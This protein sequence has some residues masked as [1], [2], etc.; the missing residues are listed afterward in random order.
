M[1]IYLL[2]AIVLLTVFDSYS[3]KEIQIFELSP[4]STITPN[5]GSNQN[6]TIE[7][8]MVLKNIENGGLYGIRAHNSIIDYVSLKINDLAINEIES[9]LYEVNNCSIGDT[10]KVKIQSDTP[11]IFPVTLN[12]VENLKVDILRTNAFY[13]VF[14]GLFLAIILYNLFL[15]ISIRD[16]I[17]FWYVLATLFI[18]LVQLQI[19][20]ILN[21]WMILKFDGNTQLLGALSGIFTIEFSAL[22]LSLRKNSKIIFLISRFALIIYAI[23]ILLIFI[24]FQSLSYQLIN[25]NASISLLLLLASIQAIIRE[26]GQHVFFL[27]AWSSFLLGVTF[28]ALKDFGLLPFNTFTNFALPVG[29]VIEILLLSF[30]LADRINV[31]KQEKEISQ[32]L[33]F[34]TMQ[35]NERLVKE[36]NTYLEN[37]VHERTLDLENRNSELNQ[38]L[39]DL[40]TTQQQLVESEKLA[41]LG[42]MTAGIAHEINNPINF[43]Q[44]NVG[45]LKRDVQDILSLLEQYANLENDSDLQ[46]KLNNLKAQYKNLEIDFLKEEISQLLNGIEE[47]SKRTAEI[48]KGLRI[49]SRMDKSERVSADINECLSS[50]LVV[51]KNMTKAEVTL[52]IHLAKD[53]PKI[54]CYPGKLSQV[55]MN[56]ITNA[57]QATKLPNR[58]PKDRIIT[59]ESV[60]RNEY[61]LIHISDNGAGIPDKIHDKIFEPFFTTKDVGEGT[62]L[63]LSIVHGIV[64]EHNGIIDFQNVPEGGT[65]FTIHLPITNQL[66][67]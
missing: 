59:I 3:Q 23:S 18:G 39:A 5:F 49:F 19:G 58:Q 62:G 7:F 43:V 50:T 11:L 22:Y 57:V 36:Q 13:L 12:R 20:G 21:Q 54:D 45:P 32:Q 14:S 4:E 16:K 56:L 48:V 44:S 66:H 55:F 17:Y 53:L 51:M 35:E 67:G 15:F 27:V 63:G 30:A 29:S 24:G 8:W 6:D 9:N 34:T 64:A 10:I 37:K 1:R 33:A 28:F 31:L 41:S 26:A 61:I 42:Q 40:K 46:L 60:Q 47:G 38:A 52:N 2:F 65:R 25:L